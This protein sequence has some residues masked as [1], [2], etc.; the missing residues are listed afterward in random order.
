MNPKPRA[1]SFDDFDFNTLTLAECWP[2]IK[3]AIVI[4]VGCTIAAVLGLFGLSFAN[5]SRTPRCFAQTVFPW[6][7]IVRE[8]LM[9]LTR[10]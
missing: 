4:L 8:R 1:P 5:L 10:R 3:G 7:P 2:W 9:T 6:P